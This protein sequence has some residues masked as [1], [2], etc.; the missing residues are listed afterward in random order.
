MNQSVGEYL[1]LQNSDGLNYKNAYLM[2]PFD[3]ESVSA[4][5]PTAF[6]QPQN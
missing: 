2:C 4:A 6:K 3:E 1:L 5:F